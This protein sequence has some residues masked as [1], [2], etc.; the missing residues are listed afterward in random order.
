MELVYTMSMTR[1]IDVGKFQLQELFPKYTRS[2]EFMV[3]TASVQIWIC[4]I[5]LHKEKTDCASSANAIFT[6]S[7]IMED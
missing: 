1:A 6:N 5:M 4:F 3:Q 7:F 2:A